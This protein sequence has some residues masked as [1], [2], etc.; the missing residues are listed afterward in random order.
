MSPVPISWYLIL[1]AALFAIGS[2]G[3]L[4][5][6]NG[7]SI[8][9]SIELML[10]AANLTLVAYARQLGDPTGQLIVFFVMAVAAAEAA[11]GLAL[12]IAVFRQRRTIDVNRM[13]LMRW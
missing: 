9:L 8:F 3:A 7:I 1:A 2:A 10:N 11:V 13:N 5:R 6:R 12:F 4:T